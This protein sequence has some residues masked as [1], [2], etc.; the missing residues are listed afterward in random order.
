MENAEKIIEK[1]RKV[2][3]LS[4]NNPSEHEA[5]AAALKAQDL[6]M[7]YH[8]TQVDIEDTISIE[9][10]SEKYAYVGN[11]NKWKYKLANIV[12]RNFRCKCYAIESHTVVFYGYAIDA[13]IAVE[14]FS[15]LF[16]EGKKAANRYY[17][18]EKK[19]GGYFFDGSGLKN[20]FL[21]GYLQGIKEELERQCTALMVVV[22]T[23]VEEAYNEKSKAFKVA[24]KRIKSRKNPMAMNEGIKFG[25]SVMNARKLKMQ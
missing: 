13:Q 18:K 7:K 14:V 22:P 16:E 21:C 24:T 2:L 23:E 9:E 1:I 12:S 15:F 17:N 20:T 8:I 25:R 5:R 4:K 10:I 6:M 19:K 11:G 3:E